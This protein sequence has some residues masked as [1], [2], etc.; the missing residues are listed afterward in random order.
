MGVIFQQ[1]KSHL[2]N[3]PK[4]IQFRHSEVFNPPII[5][6]LSEEEVGEPHYASR[7]NPMI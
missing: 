3:N 2:V 7:F 1:H 4:K 6:L 5:F